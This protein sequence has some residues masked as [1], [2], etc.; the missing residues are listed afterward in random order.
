MA[1]I[2]VFEYSDDPDDFSGPRLAGW[3]ND[4]SAV[5]WKEDVDDWDDFATHEELYR[6]AKGRWVRCDWTQHQGA[7]PKYWF[8]S[9]DEARTWLL[10][11]HHDAA[12]EKFFGKPE[13]EAGPN[14]G[15]RPLIG[16]KVDVRLPQEVLQR[17]AVY[18]NGRERADV[19]RELVGVGLDAVQTVNALRL[20]AKFV[21]AHA[22]RID[23]Y[24][25]QAMD[26][27]KLNSP[28]ATAEAVQQTQKDSVQLT[29]DLDAV[30]N[31]LQAAGI[32][33]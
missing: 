13:E 14:L 12:V 25:G 30:L 26:I 15:G 21:L 22:D 33:Q 28:S 20:A 3:F 11:N 32:E 5:Q 19:L 4:D 8:V 24:N 6:T 16:P 23:H 29:H 1:R 10:T 31:A 27:L 17:V 2:N 18:G 7:E 9:D